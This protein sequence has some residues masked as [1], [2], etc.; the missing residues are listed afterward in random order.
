MKTG[1]SNFLKSIYAL[2]LTILVSVTVVFAWFQLVFSTDSALSLEVVGSDNVSMQIAIEN[3]QGEPGSS[4]RLFS[5]VPGDEFIITITFVNIADF[6]VLFDLSFLGVTAELFDFEDDFGTP[7]VSDL[8]LLNVFAISYQNE[9]YDDGTGTIVSTYYSLASLYYQTNGFAYNQANGG[10]D[11]ILI[12]DEPILANE[13]KS[14]TIRIK[15]MNQVF[16]E[17]NS[18]IAAPMNLFQNRSMYIESL[19]IIE[20]E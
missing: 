14:A 1:R 7:I 8:S 16:D 17:M 6:T 10:L 5:M 15:F 11:M 3:N 19:S 13:T 4:L 2:T 9:D 18:E 20:N 12:N